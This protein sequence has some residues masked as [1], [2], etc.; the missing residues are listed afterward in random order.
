MIRAAATDD[1][2]IIFGATVDD[3]LN[4]QVWVTVVATGIGGAAAATRATGRSR[5]AP[6][7]RR[8][9]AATSTCRRSS[10]TSCPAWTPTSRSRA[11]ATSARYADTPVPAE[12]RASASSTRAASRGS[13]RN[14]QKWEFVVVETAQDALADAVYAPENVAHR[15]AR[16]RDRRRRAVPFDV[17]RCAQ[18]MMLAAWERRRRLVPERHPRR[19]RRG[20]DLRRRG[21]GDPLVRLSAAAARRRS[22]SA[23]EW[24]AR[25]NRKPLDE[26]V[27]RV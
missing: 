27:R 16:R 2:N 3:R 6:L 13:S 21:E 1:T 4:G 20:G 23:E 10:A 18:N 22:R 12:R 15:G 17:G 8:R 14:T 19:R 9:R 26:L 25:A 11:S 7:A 24:S 5:P